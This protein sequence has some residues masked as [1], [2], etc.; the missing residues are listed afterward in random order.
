M[1]HSRPLGPVYSGLVL[2]LAVALIFGTACA[3]KETSMTTEPDSPSDDLSQAFDELVTTLRAVEAD[4]RKSPSFGDE[5][6]QVGAGPD[7]NGAAQLQSDRV[8]SQGHRNDLQSEHYPDP[9]GKHQCGNFSDD[10]GG[11]GVRR[12]ARFREITSKGPVNP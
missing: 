5:A 9:S 1:T 10:D 4:I 8:V 2:T 12:D 3:H 11:Q 7:N 6:E